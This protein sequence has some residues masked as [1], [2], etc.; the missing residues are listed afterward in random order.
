MRSIIENFRNLYLGTAGD[1]PVPFA[2]RTSE[3]AEL[4]RWLDEPGQPPYLLLTAPAGRGKLA[5]LVQWSERLK[6]RQD[7]AVIFAPVSV[8]FQTN[9]SIELFK[10]LTEQLAAFH[11][12]DIL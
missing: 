12:E 11:R 5:L 8:R 4:D 9:L 3:L 2:G 1:P 6:E 7:V 10:I